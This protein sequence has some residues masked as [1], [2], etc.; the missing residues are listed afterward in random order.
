MAS[1]VNVEHTLEALIL[2]LLIFYPN[3]ACNGQIK[4]EKQRAFKGSKDLK[5]KLLE[6]LQMSTKR[7]LRFK[8]D[9]DDP[10]NPFL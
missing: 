6:V 7:T 10:I 3:Y 2:V 8:I 1:A 5:V 4:K 9:G